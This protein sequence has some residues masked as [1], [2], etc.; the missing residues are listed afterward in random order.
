MRTSMQASVLLHNQPAGLLQ[1]DSGEACSF[2]L[3][4]SYK[5]AYPRPVLAQRFLDDLDGV[6]R[7]R[8]RSP[9]WFSNL[10]PEGRLLELLSRQAGVAPQREFFLLLHLGR[11]LPGAVRVVTDDRFAPAQEKA[12]AL[13]GRRTAVDDWHFSLAGVQLKFSAN[14]EGK[15]FTIPL[16]GLGG[17]WIAK[18]PG[19]SYAQV[20]LNEYAT[21]QWARQSGIEIPDIELVDMAM[22]DGLPPQAL[23]TGE[24]KAF[25]IRRFDRRSD[26]QRVHME[27]FAQLLDLYP[28]EKYSKTNY[29]TLANITLALTGPEGLRHFIRRLVFVIASGN[30]DAHV[31][32]WSVVYPDGIQAELSPAY[33]LVSTIQYLPADKLALNFGGTKDWYAITPD[34]FRRLAHRLHVEENWVIEEV[35]ASI[36]AIWSAWR[37]HSKELGHAEP[38]RLQI[39][40]HLDALPL[41]RA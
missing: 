1:L 11:D 9:A 37:Q 19:D 15:G 20:P 25:A 35:R 38:V 39:Q 23:Q 24:S 18:L 3:L 34:T 10:L 8:T 22:I 36:D 21:M 16:S 29:E 41:M 12:A 30:G 5:T 14:R 13:E 4:E 27:D 17:Q 26:G 31:K 7:S 33:D 2:H 32:N 6:W 28:H 40:R